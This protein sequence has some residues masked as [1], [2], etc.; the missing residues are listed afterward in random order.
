VRGKSSPFRCGAD[1][2]SG[3]VLRKPLCQER[4]RYG[5]PLCAGDHNLH[6]REL[7]QYLF[8]SRQIAKSIGA[9]SGQKWMQ[10]AVEVEKKNH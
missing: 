5:F 6:V 8:Q 4:Q 3:D 2:P 10:H 1:N 7:A 9:G